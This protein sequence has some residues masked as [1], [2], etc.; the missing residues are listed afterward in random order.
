MSSKL[1]PYRDE[2]RLALAADPPASQRQLAAKYD[3]ARSTLQHF[4]QAQSLPDLETGSLASIE[5]MKILA[6]DIETRPNLAYVWGIWQQN[7][8]LNQ[9]VESVDVICWV[10][11]WVGDPQIEF[12]SVY[13]DGRETMVRRAWALLDEA[14]V[15]LHY[16]GIKFDVPHLN[17]EFVQLGLTPPSPYKQID[18]LTT[19]KRE[20]KFPSNKLAYV[21]EALG[22]EGKVEH[23]GFSLWTKCMNGDES[24]WENMR[25]YNIRDVILLEQLYEKLRP[26]VRSHPNAAALTGRDV[27]C[28]ACG[29]TNQQARGYSVLQTGRY[30]RFQCSDC[31]KWSRGTERVEKVSVVG[32][33]IT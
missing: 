25:Q 17:R 16:N 19:A 1:E 12:R 7:I 23:E 28:P 27:A 24:A 32:T 14:D 9:L 5:G 31:G 10:A 26:W 4:L 6:L 8:G 20:F 11:K 22:L 21:S 3:V 29:S 2:I 33:P 30:Q 18:L 13:H 15:V